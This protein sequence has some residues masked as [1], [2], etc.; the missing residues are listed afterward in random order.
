MSGT[1]LLGADG[2]PLRSPIDGASL[3]APNA[4]T[5][6]WTQA[7]VNDLKQAI[8]D[9]GISQDVAYSDGARVRNMPM[10]EARMLLQMMQ[11][12]VRAS[13]VPVPGR[14][15]RRSFRASFYSGY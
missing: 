9:A 3:L 7:Q 8:A 13:A 15:S 1:Q 5:G 10:A 14:P 2:A 6:G 4:P 11:D 12:D